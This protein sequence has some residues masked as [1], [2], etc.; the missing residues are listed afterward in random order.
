M[1]RHSRGTPPQSAA[2]RIRAPWWELG[3]GTKT[4][5]TLPSLLI[6]WVWDVFWHH[7]KF[8]D[9]VLGIMLG[10]ILEHYPVM[11]VGVVNT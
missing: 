8:E 5:L 10:N 4:K 2:A 7:L 9:Q 11:V 3:A 6:K 1:Q